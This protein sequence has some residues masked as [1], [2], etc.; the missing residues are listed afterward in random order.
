VPFFGVGSRHVFG[1]ASFVL[2]NTGCLTLLRCRSCGA[3]SGDKRNAGHGDPI[4]LRHELGQGWSA[5]EPN[6]ETVVDALLKTR[7]YLQ[8]SKGN[9]LKYYEN[10]LLT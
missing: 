3:S 6:P 2:S 7:P 5:A 4:P 10:V 8:S 9:A 1:G